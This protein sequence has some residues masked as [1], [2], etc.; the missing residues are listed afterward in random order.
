MRWLAFLLSS[1]VIS[2]ARPATAQHSM[3]PAPSDTTRALG[4]D[5]ATHRARTFQVKRERVWGLG[6]A[7]LVVGAASYNYARSTWGISSGRFHIKNDWSGDGLL[8]ND[9]ISHFLYGYQLTRAFAGAWAWTGYS[10]RKARTIAAIETAALLT[11]VEMPLDAF[12]S[13]QGLGVTDLAFDYLGVGVGVL[14]LKHG[15]RWDFRFSAKQ[16][17]FTSQHPLFAAEQR[18]SDNYVF[19]ATYRPALW[20]AE[21]QPLSVGIGHSA[22]RASDGSAVRELYLGVGTSVP[23]LVSVISPSVARR[24]P[25]L[26]AYFFHFSLRA[27]V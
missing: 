17:P 27:T 12:N 19:W 25:L 21:R 6:A 8:Q 9:E 23:D 22:R 1:G 11:L 18:E 14:K 16:S 3:G 15:G 26:G 4:P 7:H 24:L 20:S 2:L 13:D 5:T 10:P